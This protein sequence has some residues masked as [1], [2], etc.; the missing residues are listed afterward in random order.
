PFSNLRPPSAFLKLH[1]ASAS[2]ATRARALEGAYQLEKSRERNRST[3]K[4]EII[5]TTAGK[6]PRRRTVI[7]IARIFKDMKTM[8]VADGGAFESMK[9]PAMGSNAMPATT[10]VNNQVFLSRARSRK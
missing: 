10:T 4:L 5:I 2:A 3:V 1:T 6:S 9:N 7:T 8:S